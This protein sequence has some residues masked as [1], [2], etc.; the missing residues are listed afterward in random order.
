MD[1]GTRSIRHLRLRL[2]SRVAALWLALLF[3]LSQGGDA[4]AT[5]R[6]PLHDGAPA[7]AA[8]AHAGHHAAGAAHGGQDGGEE[9]GRCTCVGDCCGSAGVAG[10]PEA[11]VS[12]RPVLTTAAPIAAEAESGAR[13][14]R[15]PY[16]LPY[17]QAPPPVG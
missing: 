11:L 5:H 13:S 17:S 3:L 4:L 1:P 7:G 2:P 9:Q 12:L 15:R 14:L 10:S 8:G 16:L 6:C